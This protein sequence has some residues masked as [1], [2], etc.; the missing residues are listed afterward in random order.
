MFTQYG[1]ATMPLSLVTDWVGLRRTLM[2][3]RY[4][5]PYALRRMDTPIM[6]CTKYCFPLVL[7]SLL[8]SCDCALFGTTEVFLRVDNLAT[9][10]PSKDAGVTFAVIGQDVSD[11]SAGMVLDQLGILVGTTDERG[12]V[13][14][15]LT[16]FVQGALF[17]PA[18]PWMFAEVWIVGVDIEG[19]EEV[20][21]IQPSTGDADEN[22]ARPITQFFHGGSAGTVR[23]RIGGYSD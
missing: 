11:E 9:G 5:T 19:T 7:I 18:I 23:V 15:E 12:V 1:G 16:T 17:A 6:K 3:R 10:E 4:S 20:I 21:V 13:T 22:G 2:N 8:P 14:I